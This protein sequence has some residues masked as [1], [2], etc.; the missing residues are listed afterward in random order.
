[1]SNGKDNPCFAHALLYA[2]NNTPPALRFAA[3]PQRDNQR[4][5][6]DQQRSKSREATL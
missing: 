6:G 1:M 5:A 3:G 2:Q 4:T